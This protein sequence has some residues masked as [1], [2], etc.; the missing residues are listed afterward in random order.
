MGPALLLLNELLK[1]FLWFISVLPKTIKTKYSPLML[2][3]YTQCTGNVIFTVD[4][5]KVCMEF[6]LCFRSLLLFVIEHKHIY[7]I[8]LNFTVS[9]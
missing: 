1:I 6:Y 5:L 4:H 9:L 2:H 8:V 3:A 7:D